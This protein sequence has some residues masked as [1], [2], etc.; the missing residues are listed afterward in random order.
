[1]LQPEVVNL[2]QQAKNERKRGLKESALSAGITA[3]V[4][5]LGAYSGFIPTQLTALCTA[6]GA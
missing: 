2:E 6:V 5:A 3:R 4:V 1:M